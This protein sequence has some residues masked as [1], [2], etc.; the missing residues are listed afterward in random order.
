[1]KVAIVVFPGT[2]CEFDVHEVLK[3]QFSIEAKFVSPEETNLQSYDV[4]LIPGGASYG[5]AIRPGAVAARQPVMDAIREASQQGKLI[6]GIGNGFQI[7][8]EA[9]LL[10]GI[11]LQNKDLKFICQGQKLK[12]ENNS[13]FTKNY[14]DGEIISIPIAHKFGQYYCDEKTYEKLVEEK[15]IVFTYYENN[16]NGSIGNIAGIVNEERNVLGMMPH[17]ERA[18]NQL[19]GSNDGRK[20][21]QSI[22]EHGRNLK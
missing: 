6:I 22:V 15:R 20:F 4:I 2:S 1:M 19:F 16:P 10:P 18:C 7:L 9:K 5:D 21:F 14:D 13:P 17:P 11:L 8:L 3:E 12:V